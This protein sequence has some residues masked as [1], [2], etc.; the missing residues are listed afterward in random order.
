M[1]IWVRS[2]FSGRQRAALSAAGYLARRS[3]GEFAPPCGADSNKCEVSRAQASSRPQSITPDVLKRWRRVWGCDCAG[4][5][6]GADTEV[7]SAESGLRGHLRTVQ[8][9]TG[10]RPS[11]C[12]WRSLYDPLVQEVLHLMWSEQPES[13]LEEECPALLVEAL[14]V[15]IRARNATRAEDMRLEDERRKAARK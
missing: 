9:V 12:P 8:R 14:G 6:L 13:L 10:T 3:S 2:F 1:V 15:Y 11:T 4:E 5:D 7:G